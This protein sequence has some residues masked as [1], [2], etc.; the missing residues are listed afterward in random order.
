MSLLKKTLDKYPQEVYN[1]LSRDGERSIDLS[2][3][4]RMFT[5]FH[6]GDNKER[7][8]G[9]RATLEFWYNKVTDAYNANPDLFNTPPVFSGGFFRDIVHGRYPNDLDLFV[10]SHGLTREEAEDNLCLFLSS[11]G[12]KF[13]EF[14]NPEYA[15]QQGAFRVFEV[16]A[17]P[18]TVCTFQIILKDMGPTEDNPLY[19]T[20]DFH[21]NHGKYALAAGSSEVYAHS[22]CVAG[23]R[24]K[25]HIYRGE[26]GKAECN[27]KF[28]GSNGYKW[29][30]LDKQDDP[31]ERKKAAIKKRNEEVAKFVLDNRRAVFTT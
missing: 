30:D 9:L 24:D 14:E 23:F 21:Y 11:M 16:Y 18:G 15:G 28:W 31:L 6:E 25:V 22:E 4:P 3:F 8:D 12:E 2:H 1:I 20:K 26:K 27:D 7:E 19:V 10:N 13:V 17:V 29:F 5:P